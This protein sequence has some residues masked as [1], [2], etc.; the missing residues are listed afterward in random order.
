M[1]VL[2]VKMMII[3]F[4]KDSCVNHVRT[5]L[6]ATFMASTLSSFFSPYFAF[7]SLFYSVSL[8]LVFSPCIIIINNDAQG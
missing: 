2:S 5:F 1:R 4:Q 8:L 6:G 3:F 7:A